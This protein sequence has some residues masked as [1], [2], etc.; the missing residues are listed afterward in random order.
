LNHNWGI[1]ETENTLSCVDYLATQTVIDRERMAIRGGSPTL[2]ALVTHPRIFAAGCSLF[3][4]G[5]L[6]RLVKMIHNSESRY[7]PDL[8]FLSDIPEEKWEEINRERNPGVHAEKFETLVVLFRGS[9]DLVV[10]VQQALEMERVMNGR[11][12]EIT[13]ICLKA[14]DTD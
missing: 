8:L 4:I 5:N 1:K 2:Q 14:K 10:P 3:G 13:L 6:K 9:E 12:K 11:G 7:I